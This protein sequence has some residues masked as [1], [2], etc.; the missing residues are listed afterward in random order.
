MFNKRR[1]YRPLL[2]K[3]FGDSEVRRPPV[4]DYTHAQRAGN[5]EQIMQACN[6]LREGIFG[7]GKGCGKGRWEGVWGNGEK[8]GA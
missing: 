7:T 1:Q 4:F 6:R 3:I 8:E 2:L 5:S